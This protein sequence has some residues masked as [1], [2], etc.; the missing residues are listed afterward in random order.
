MENE[1]EIRQAPITTCS[2]CDRGWVTEIWNI[3]MYA[4]LPGGDKTRY[5][6]R[7]PNGCVPNKRADDGQNRTPF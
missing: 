2:L 7:C 5:V 4:H 3:P 6:R 1:R